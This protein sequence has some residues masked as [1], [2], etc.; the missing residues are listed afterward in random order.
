MTT[1]PTAEERISNM[2]ARDCPHDPDD[3]PKA[4]RYYRS[5]SLCWISELEAAEAAA[6]EPL[7]QRIADLVRLSE[8]FFRLHDE[9]S[10]GSYGDAEDAFRDAIRAMGDE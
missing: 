2:M 1:K 9:H 8:E 6:R 7:E 10:T 5:C 4:W 3:Y